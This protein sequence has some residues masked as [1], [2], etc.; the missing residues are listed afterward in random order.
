MMKAG[1]VVTALLLSCLLAD[2]N[3]AGGMVL[4]GLDLG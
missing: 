2:A 4:T 1:F 3:A